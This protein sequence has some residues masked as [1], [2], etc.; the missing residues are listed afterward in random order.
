MIVVI[1]EPKGAIYGGVVAA[2]VFKSIAGQT[3]SYLNVP[4]DDIR[5]K[6]LLLVAK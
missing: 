5:E 1:Y 6:N 2:P 4:R 3:L